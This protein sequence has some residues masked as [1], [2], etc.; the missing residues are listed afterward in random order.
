MDVLTPATRSTRRC[1]SRRSYPDA[2]FVQG[3]TDVLVELNFDRSPP[4]GADQPER[5]R[6]AARLRPARTARFVLGAG[7]HLR[8]GDAR[9][10]RRAS[11]PRWRRRRA[12]SAR[13]RS[14]TAAR[15]AATSAPRRPPA[16]RCRRCSS[17]TPRCE[18]RERPG[19]AAAAARASSSSASKQNALEPDELDRRGARR[20]EPGA[21]D[22]HEG[23]AAERDGDLRL[24]ARAPRRP[25]ARRAA[26]GVRLGRPRPLRLVTARST[27]RSASR[28]SSPRARARSTTSAAPPPT[29][30]TRSRVLTAPRA[31]EVP[32]MKITLTVNG[33]PRE[34][35]VWGGESLLFALREQLGLPGSK[36]A[37]EQ[38]ECG[39]CSVLLDGTLVCA[40]LVLAAQADGHEVVTVEGLAP[41]GSLPP[42]AGGVRRGRR[43]AVRVL[44]AGPDRRDRRPARAHPEPD[45]TTRSGRRSPA[46][47]A[48]ARATRRSST[49]SGR[50]PRA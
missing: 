30:A 34:A 15:S 1:A 8:R 41:D 23:R 2:R 19:R 33:E 39:S 10:R 48:A 43:R 25:R 40:C 44:H 27:R 37:C 4:A 45:P 46:T 18:R 3:G 9:R 6:R 36:N 49:P 13:R 50:R 38:G 32:R 7:P 47:S 5:G 24:L 20:A 28:S 35:D 29:G 16:T 26:R 11:C 21:A 17:R 22:V 42:R 14:A 31:R 12:R